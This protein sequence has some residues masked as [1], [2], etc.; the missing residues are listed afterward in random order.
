M[1][2]LRETLRIET[3]KEPG[4][5]LITICNY[6]YYQDPKNY[7]RT[8]ERTMDRTI[9]E[10]QVNQP[11]PDI[12]KNNKNNKKEDSQNKN[13]ISEI[14]EEYNKTSFPKI[15]KLSEARKT[16]IKVRLKEYGKDKIIEVINMADESDFL[17]GIN[18]NGWK[19]NFDWIINSA[20]FIKIMEGNYKNKTT[21]QL[22]IQHIT[23][24]TNETELR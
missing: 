11:L 7:E 16:H 5:V 24:V 13:E 9:V 2:F 22:Q 23:V 17:R 6:D 8:N 14:I 21:E 18:K 20:N 4:G 19:A 10:P 12:Y 3:T 1:K 15:Q